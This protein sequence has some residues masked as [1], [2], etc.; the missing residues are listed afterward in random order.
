MKDQLL[1]WGFKNKV[2]SDWYELKGVEIT[3]VLKLV[4]EDIESVT[5]FIMGGYP[6]QVPN[7]NTKLALFTFL[8]NLGLIE[9]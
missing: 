2:G 3:I 5:I 4:N 6:A 8:Y 7:C 9:I 1:K